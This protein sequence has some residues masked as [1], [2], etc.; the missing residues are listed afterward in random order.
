MNENVHKMILDRDVE[1]S[2]LKD[3][4]LVTSIEV[5]KLRE[6][7]ELL[8]CASVIPTTKQV[9]TMKKIAQEAIKQTEGGGGR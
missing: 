9:K 5:K 3:R 2:K 6:A 1:I 7:L 4:L 8:A